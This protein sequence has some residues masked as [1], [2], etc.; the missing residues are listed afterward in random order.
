MSE[1]AIVSSRK[2]RLEHLAKKGNRRSRI[3]LDLANSPGTFLSTVQVGITAIG[4]IAGAVSGAALGGK[5]AGVFAAIP[6]LRPYSELLG[7]VV[8]VALTTYF[9]LIIGE[10][11][12]KRIGLNNPENIALKV[13]VPMRILSRV[14]RPVVFILNTST[15]LLLKIL[16][17]K[18]SR[19]PAVTEEE[20]RMLIRQGNKAGIIENQ[21][22]DILESV[23]RLGDKRVDGV[24]TP[25]TMISWLDISAPEEENLKLIKDSQYSVYPVCDESLDNILG[26][27]R[28][29]D[30]FL[31]GND[32]GKLDLRKYLVEPLYVPEGTRALKLLEKFK[33]THKSFAVVVDEYG[34]VQGMVTITDLVEEVLGE[35]SQEPAEELQ[36]VQREDGSWLIDGMMAIDEFKELFSIE[37]LPGE[38]NGEFQTIGGF[39]INRLEKIPSTGEKFESTGLSFEIVDMDG[40]RIDKIL[41][42]KH[43][44]AAAYE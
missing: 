43:T 3:A 7:Y 35:L 17:I 40:N 26:I 2:G 33:Q 9:S 6:A 20:I 27:V 24:M 37:Y 5:L 36:A 12:P 16:N 34:G 4:I 19:E 8:V 30:V 39:V 42:M 18:P 25:R 29:K 44:S 21:E 11:V 1:I 14:G 28:L 23:F 15:E 32:G 22:Q 10:L 41:V 13:A 38:E 31:L